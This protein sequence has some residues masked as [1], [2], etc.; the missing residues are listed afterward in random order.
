MRIAAVDYGKRRIGLSISDEKKRIA[1][2]L[3]LVD[4]GKNL[5]ES[6]KQILHAL[7][8]YLTHLE[9]IL[10][11]LP[12]LM[13][14]TRGDMALL[15]DNLKKILETLT[16]IPIE[17]VDERLTSAQA[18]KELKGLDYSR[19]ERKTLVD[20]TAATLLLQAYLDLKMQS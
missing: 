18:E 4:A 2:P 10:V 8:P 15:V 20:S 5:E 19:K 17:C 16:P 13:N 12:L 6:S 14:G 3:K 11:G 7:T 9:K 1:L